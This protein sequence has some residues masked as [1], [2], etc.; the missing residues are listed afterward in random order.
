MPNRLVNITG[1]LLDGGM[2]LLSYFEE[3]KASPRCRALSAASAQSRVATDFLFVRVHRGGYHLGE[4]F[5]TVTERLTNAMQGALAAA[6]LPAPEEV[7]WEVPRQPEHGDYSS[8]VAMV[9]AKPARRSPRQIADEIVGRLDTEA[10]G[11][12]SVDVQGPGFINFR[13]RSDYLADGLRAI[14]AAE[15]RY[16]HSESGAGQPVMVEFVSANPTGPLHIGHGRQAALGD[17]VAELL[18]WAGWVVHREFY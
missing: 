1:V 16:G 9:L 7:L 5:M 6:G 10:A 18:A 3:P 15:E 17:A 12:R 14:L 4:A 11:V 8:N 13:L 2:V